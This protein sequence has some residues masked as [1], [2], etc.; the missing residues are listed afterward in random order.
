MQIPT[1]A[2][3]SKPRGA[4][5]FVTGSILPGRVFGRDRDAD[6]DRDHAGEQRRATG[7]PGLA[8]PLAGGGRAARFG[9]LELIYD[10]HDTPSLLA[11]LW[12][13]ILAVMVTFTCLGLWLLSA[14]T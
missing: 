6:L 7:L 2:I 4:F 13:A 8:G 12:L 5:L 1:A 11:S 9:W 10:D 3:S 14:V